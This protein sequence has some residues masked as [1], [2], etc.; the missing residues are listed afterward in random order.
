[1][2]EIR[3][4]IICP[5]CGSENCVKNGRA[6]GKQ[7]YLCKECYTRFIINR[8]KKK[9]PRTIKFKAVKMYKEGIS[10]SKIA[11]LLDIPVQNISYWIKVYVKNRIK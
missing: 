8:Q 6:K 2:G 11:K 3:K 9:Y 10:I 4:K 5:D 1:M 7:T